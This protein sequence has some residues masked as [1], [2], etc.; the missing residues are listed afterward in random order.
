MAEGAENCAPANPENNE[1]NALLKQLKYEDGTKPKFL[2]LGCE[3]ELR[4]FVI[5]AFGNGRAM[6]EDSDGLNWSKDA[7]HNMVSFKFNGV[8]FKFYT[9]TSTLVIQGQQEVVV[10]EKLYNLVSGL[11]KEA[12]TESTV[13]DSVE[14][15]REL[16]TNTV[17]DLNE[18]SVQEIPLREAYMHERSCNV[19]KEIDYLKKEVNKLSGL[20]NLITSKKNM[21]IERDVNDTPY[22]NEV[23]LLRQQ[24]SDL[25]IVNANLKSKIENLEKEKES[26]LTVIRILHEDK[27]HRTSKLVG[28]SNDNK[29][30]LM[31]EKR[32]R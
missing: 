31:R 18:S 29:P 21:Q 24:V 23:S 17:E 15:N 27:Q 8:T 25:T 5:L 10:N 19:D 32:L 2:W 22:T 14:E 11:S 9:T 30:C 4:K 20:M 16:K 7:K 26:F 12:F 13:K 3:E 28:K 6:V 1:F